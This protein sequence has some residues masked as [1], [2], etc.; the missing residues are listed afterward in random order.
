[1]S[2]DR[3]LA[4][5]LA[6]NSHKEHERIDELAAEKSLYYEL[7]QNEQ[8]KIALGRSDDISINY[9]ARDNAFFNC[10][11]AARQLESKVRFLSDYSQPIARPPINQHEARIS[12]WLER[13]NPD[14]TK[15]L[16]DYEYFLISKKA[17]EK[18]IDRLTDAINDI[19]ADIRANLFPRIL[20]FLLI[21]IPY[22][23][24][25]YRMF[26]PNNSLEKAIDDGEYLQGK[27]TEYENSITHENDQ[28]YQQWHEKY[29][30]YTAISSEQLSKLRAEK[31]KYEQIT[32]RLETAEKFIRAYAHPELSAA[33]AHFKKQPT[34]ANLFDLNTQLSICKYTN[35]TAQQDIRQLDH[36]IDTLQ[37]L[38]PEVKQELQEFVTK[39]LENLVDRDVYAM[40]HNKYQ[41]LIE[42]SKNLLE[43]FKKNKIAYGK[44]LEK[45][46]QLHPV[47]DILTIPEYDAQL[48]TLHEQIE[49][50]EAILSTRRALITPY[51]HVMQTRSGESLRQFYAFTSAPDQP[52]YHIYAD[53]LRK[54]YPAALQALAQEQNNTCTVR[55]SDV[56]TL[57]EEHLKTLHTIERA[58]D[59]KMIPYKPLASALRPLLETTE[60]SWEHLNTI[61]TAIKKNP[62]YYQ[63]AGLASLL[64]KVMQKVSEARQL[65]T[66]FEKKPHSPV[67]QHP[68]LLMNQDNPR[69]TF[70]QPPV[71]QESAASQIIRELLG[72]MNAYQI[73]TSDRDVSSDQKQAIINDVGEN[74][75][76]YINMLS[77]ADNQDISPQHLA[78]LRNIATFVTR[79]MNKDNHHEFNETEFAH[80]D[81]QLEQLDREHP[82]RKATEFLIKTFRTKTEYMAVDTQTARNK[83]QRELT[84][85]LQYREK[86]LTKKTTKTP[87]AI[88]WSAVLAVKTLI[89]NYANELK[90]YASENNASEQHLVAQLVSDIDRICTI[91]GSERHNQKSVE[92]LPH[93]LQQI[94]HHCEELVKH[95]MSEAAQY[96]TATLKET[97]DYAGIL[98]QTHTHSLKGRK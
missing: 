14:H 48:Q 29:A 43:K 9:M 95:P 86:V 77:S 82:I 10:L 71:K 4:H 92:S 27:L 6:A 81:R 7:F 94:E 11:H 96:I 61:E 13:Y 2:K 23:Y 16:A 56:Y 89:K 51:K 69:P 8:H 67:S 54:L 98:T 93:L 31:T 17:H 68:E 41:Q 63:H 72:D 47:R 65:Q 91:I 55:S 87:N 74:M 20:Y 22:V 35:A 70:F 34:Y 66:K 5:E 75:L 28:Y 15:Y 78:L 58:T 42:S 50:G 46:A 64:S 79:I 3:S 19:Y 39:T 36:V 44:T 97:E 57:A 18:E 26:S 37:D 49:K 83:L 88:R 40:L 90:K 24:G 1:M 73:S 52:T 12:S 76:R 21:W 62:T 32:Q 85:E 80:V 38:Y 59:P 84:N 45:R 33:Y 25:I 53:I 30:E 60:W